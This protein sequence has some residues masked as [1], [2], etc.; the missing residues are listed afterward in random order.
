MINGVITVNTL[1]QTRLHTG[2]E[3]RECEERFL[4]HQAREV[5]SH[6]DCPHIS[7][8]FSRCYFKVNISL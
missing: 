7:P 2:D 4:E 1:E 8:V 5:R 6:P 3:D